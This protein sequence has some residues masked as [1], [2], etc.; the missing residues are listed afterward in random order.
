[1]RDLYT[2]YRLGNLDSP[3]IK[4]MSLEDE[5]DVITFPVTDLEGNEDLCDLY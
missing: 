2:N 4:A 5:Q 1:M 3:A